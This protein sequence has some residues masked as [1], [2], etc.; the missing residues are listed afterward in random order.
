MAMVFLIAPFLVRIIRWQPTSHVGSGHTERATYTEKPEDY[1]NLMNR[2]DRK[3]QTAR[4]YV[5]KPEIFQQSGA[6]VGI[7]AFGSSHFAIQEGRDY[8]KAKNVP[9]DYLR[10]RALP[11]TE[12]LK[13]FVENHERIYVIEQ[14]RDC[15]LRDLVRVELPDSSTKIRSVRHY[16]GLPLDAEY[17]TAAIMKQER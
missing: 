16:N 5:P 10:L 17:V 14:N 9:T 7:I 8:L 1:V 13:A 15:Q 11:F 3:F 2:L 12:E 4:Q 6:K